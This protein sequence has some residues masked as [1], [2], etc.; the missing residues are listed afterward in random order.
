MGGLS[1]ITH[2]YPSYTDVL[3]LEF[4]RFPELSAESVIIMGI[5]DK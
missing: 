5:G 1:I 4:R 3:L 2:M